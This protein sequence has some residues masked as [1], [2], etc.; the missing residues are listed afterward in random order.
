[1]SRPSRRPLVAALFALAASLSSSACL[2]A[3]NVADDPLD[4]PLDGEAAPT[5]DRAPGPD[6][7]VTVFDAVPVFFTGADNRRVVDATARL[8][9]QGAYDAITLR[10]A[11]SCPSGGCDP[12]DRFA[13]LGVVHTDDGGAERTVELAR[14]ITPFGV[15]A[16]FDVD[17]TSLRPLLRGAVT[18]RAFIDTWVG[19][20][21][22]YGDGWLLTVI[23]DLHGG[24]PARRPVVVQPV[25]SPTAVVYGDPARPPAQT[26]TLTLPTSTTATTWELRALVTGHGQGNADNCAEFCARTHALSVGGAARERQVW[27]DDCETTA[28]PRQQGTWQYPRAGW[29]P[30]ADVRPWVE[31]VSDAIHTAQARGDLVVGWDVEAYDNTCWPDVSTCAACTLGTG[32]DYDGGAHTEPVF[33]LSALLVGFDEP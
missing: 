23:V 31:D 2:P 24:V 3:A 8:P 5:L 21:S 15:G 4:D 1:M 14:F 29:C 11:L 27:R 18:F 17:A 10:I 32:C 26:T 6:A 25:W 19:P 28:A 33:Q 7:F 13:S 16:G 30:G 20:G 22:G 12:W 9:E